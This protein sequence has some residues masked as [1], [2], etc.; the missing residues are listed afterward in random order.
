[1]QTLQKNPQD[2]SAVRIMHFEIKA[3]AQKQLLVE[4]AFQLNSALNLKS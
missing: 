3:E 1:M 4:T 2:Y